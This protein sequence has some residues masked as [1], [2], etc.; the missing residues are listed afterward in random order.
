MPKQKSV[1]F[2]STTFLL[3][4]LLDQ[5]TKFWALA[6]LRTQDKYILP[7]LDLSFSW[8]RGI[9][10]G[11]LN[12]FSRHGFMILTLFIAVIILFFLYY[13]IDQYR[14]KK[15]VFCETLVLSGAISNLFD[16]IYHGAVI[17]FIDLHVGGWHWPTFNIADVCIVVGVLGIVLKGLAWKQ[18][19]N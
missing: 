13:C 3:F 17:D 14:Q 10:W 9:S 4:L 1:F 2:Y 6:H 18:W 19:E 15:T 11:L 8:N 12:R 16:R 5:V 7:V